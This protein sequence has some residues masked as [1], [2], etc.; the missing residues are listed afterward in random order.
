M[1]HARDDRRISVLGAAILAGITLITGLVV[2]S[3]MQRQAEFILGATLE[4]SL[5]SR[6]SQLESAIDNGLKDFVTVA[7]RPF[8]I[9]QLNRINVEPGDVQARQGL[10]RIANSFIPTGLSA[11]SIVSADGHEIVRAGAFT[12]TVELQTL[13]KAPH[14]RRA[15]T[16]ELRLGRRKRHHQRGGLPR[17]SRSRRV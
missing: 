8:L 16:Y 5:Q 14:K 9:S 4:L 6:A 10:Q 12:D 15:L 3:I 1:K 2:Y 17:A 11:L 7:T 13:I